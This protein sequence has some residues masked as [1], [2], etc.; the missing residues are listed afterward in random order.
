MCLNDYWPV[1]L[2][3]VVMKYLEKLVRSHIMTFLSPSFDPNQFT[4]RTNRSTEDAVAT[5]PHMTLTHLEQHG[6]YTLF[7][8]CS[9]AFNTILPL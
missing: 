4:H 3:L 1:A 6:N 5:A 9:L 7:V 8:D 2:T